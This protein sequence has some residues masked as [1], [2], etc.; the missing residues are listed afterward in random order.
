MLNQEKTSFDA[1]RGV[2]LLFS[3]RV[4][5]LAALQTLSGD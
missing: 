2:Y 4:V 5:S 3:F 1:Q